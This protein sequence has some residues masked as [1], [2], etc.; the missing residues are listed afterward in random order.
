MLWKLVAQLTR[1]EKTRMT[2]EFSGGDPQLV[3][4]P[5]VKFPENLEDFLDQQTENLGLPS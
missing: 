3:K 4:I 5:R 1:K 2:L